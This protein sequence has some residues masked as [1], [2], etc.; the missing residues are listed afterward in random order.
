MKVSLL[1]PGVCLLLPLLEPP[2][3][4]ERTLSIAESEHEIV[5]L[6]VKNK[7]YLK[8]FKSFCLN[9]LVHAEITTNFF[10]RNHAK[11]NCTRRS[12]MLFF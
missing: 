6:L 1:L 2:Q 9:K 3:T 10:V 8:L 4:P 5:M 12:F 7:S 11:V